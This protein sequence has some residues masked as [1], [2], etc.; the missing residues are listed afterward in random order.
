MTANAMNVWGEIVG[1]AV[2]AGVLLIFGILTAL[3]ARRPTIP[4]GSKG[5]REKGAEGTHEVI[6]ADGYIDSFAGVIEEAGGALPPVVLISVIAIPLWWLIYMI[7]N[8]SPY[9]VNIITFIRSTYRP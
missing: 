2:G 3:M 5:R 9:L 1:I 6:A 4:P 8:W 7:I